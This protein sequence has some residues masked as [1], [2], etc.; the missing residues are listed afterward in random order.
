MM[1]ELISCICITNNRPALL[2]RSIRCYLM[3]TYHSK[4]LVVSYP[5]DDIESALLLKNFRDLS[6]LNLIEIKRPSDESLGTARNNAI[7]KCEGKYICIWDDDDWH[8]QDRLNVQ[9]HSIV[10]NKSNYVGSIL[11]RIILYDGTK[12]QAYLSFAYHWDGTLLCRKE[13][14]FQ[15]QYADRNKAE[16]TQVIPFLVN[17]NMISFIE[18]QP[19]LY[20]YVYHG[21]NT[22][23]YQHFQ[24]FIN[25]S[26]PLKVEYLEKVKT[27]LRI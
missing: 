18:E 22:W 2:Q 25:Q 7:Y 15:N 27:F 12:D 6:A 3:Q 23:N 20:I 24:I 1:T 4:Q 13:V 19:F 5:T 21:G 26:F 14:L 8:H 9:L 11:N 10:D 16:D 17:R